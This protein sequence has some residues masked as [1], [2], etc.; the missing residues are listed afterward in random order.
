MLSQYRRYGDCVGWISE[1]YALADLRLIISHQ[2]ANKWRERWRPT[3][4]LHP[5]SL[6]C[7]IP[8][9]TSGQKGETSFK[10]GFD[11][12]AV[13][14]MMRQSNETRILVRETQIQMGFRSIAQNIWGTIFSPNHMMQVCYDW[15]NDNTKSWWLL[16]TLHCIGRCLS[17]H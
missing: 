8:P 6:H 15:I 3:S 13:F 12:R 5:S 2:C 4:I 14:F 7:C 9:L 11:R 1:F 16:L 17:Q 10:P